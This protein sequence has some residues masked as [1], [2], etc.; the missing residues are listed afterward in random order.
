MFFPDRRRA[1]TEA[2]RVLAPGGR[3]LFSSWTAIA[4]N[5]LS[6]LVEEALAARYP[7]S[8]PRFLSRTPFGY[9]AREAIE[10]DV[11]AAGFA[12]ITVERVAL[13]SPAPSAR[14]PAVGLCQ[15]CPLRGEIEALEPGGLEA[16]TDAAARGIAARLG[17]GA[18]D[19]AMAAW[20][21]SAEP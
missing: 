5:E 13:R 14:E 17:D 6:L 1:F 19:A 2:R 9:H 20:V 11:R 12:K 15:G 7:S 21:V 10:A 16:A 8:P 3:F 4:E 18:V